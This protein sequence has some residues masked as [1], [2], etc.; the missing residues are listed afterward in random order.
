MSPNREHKNTV[1]TALFKEKEALIELY[2]ALTDSDYPPDTEIEISTLQGVL[3]LNS[4]NDIS[5]VLDGKIV[6][7]IEHQSTVSENAPL[8]LLVYVARVYE[9]LVD[10]RAMYGQKLIKIPTPELIVLYNGTASFPEEKTLRLS[11]AFIEAPKQDGS[12]GSLELAVRVLNIN[13]GY[14]G[15]MVNRSENLCGYVSFIDK[16]RE[17]TNMGLELG[18]AITRAVRF[19]EENNILQPFLSEH[20]SE[21]EN[22]LTAEFVMADAIE[23]WREEGIEIGLERGREQG[24]ERG[25]EEATLTFLSLLESGMTIEEIKAALG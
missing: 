10:K 15:E 13:A 14:N 19:C 23:V 24:L 22:M 5:F 2:N 4:M 7:L 16:V 1:F 17:G 11:D 9:K 3:Y 25:R 12:M 18:E 6:L 21:V 20:A 8:R